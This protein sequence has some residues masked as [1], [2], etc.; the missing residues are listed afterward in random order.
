[1]GKKILVLAFGT[2]TP[3]DSVA[4]DLAREL[5]VRGVEFREARSLDDF[6]DAAGSGGR[7]FVMDVV[8]GLKRVEVIE[9]AGLL[10]ERRLF[11]LHDFDVGFF[12]RLLSATG[13]AGVKI[14]GV[15]WGMGK[16]AA[17]EGVKELLEKLV[18]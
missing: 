15:P 11:S 7:V 16:R 18:A 1:M 14:I 12:L 5:R 8:K 13:R 6:L 10:K 2:R 17:R 9:D 4:L 3:G